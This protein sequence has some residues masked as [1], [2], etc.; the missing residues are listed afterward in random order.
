MDRA[1]E[2]YKSMELR[3]FHGSFYYANVQKADRTDYIYTAVC[4][5][6]ILL[7]R[8]VNV[9]ELLGSLLV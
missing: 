1:Q 2:L 6:M 5:G 3:G 4:I 7:L 8:F 9:S